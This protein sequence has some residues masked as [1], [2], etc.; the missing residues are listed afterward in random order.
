MVNLQTDRL[1]SQRPFLISGVGFCGPFHTSYRIRGKQPFKTY[2]AVFVCLTSNAVHFEIVSALSTSNFLLFFKRFIGR[3]G[4]PIKIYYDNATKFIGARSMLK[5]LQPT[6][7]QKEIFFPTARNVALSFVL[8]ITEHRTLAAFGKLVLSLQNR[9]SSKLLVKHTSASKN[10]KPLRDY[11]NDGDVLTPAHLLISC[12]LS[13]PT[14]SCRQCTT[15]CLAT[16]LE[17]KT[18]KGTMQRPIQKIARYCSVE[19]FNRGSMLKELL[20]LFYIRIYYYIF[21]L[22]YIIVANPANV[23]LPFQGIF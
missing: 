12:S 18:K 22:F 23:V 16:V 13:Q 4:K 1:K 6:K 20:I 14:S 3:R 21:I 8:S 15:S 10:C 17:V 11:P 9:F 2:L 7:Q 19:D 5:E